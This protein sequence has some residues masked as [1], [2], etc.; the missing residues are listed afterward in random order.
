MNSNNILLANKKRFFLFFIVIFFGCNLYSQD[1]CIDPDFQDKSIELLREFIDD[2]TYLRCKAFNSSV[3]KEIEFYTIIKRN[4][5]YVFYIHQKNVDAENGM[6]IY[7]YDSHMNLVASSIDP[8]TKKNTSVIC[9]MP[10]EAGR[11]YLKTTYRTSEDKCCLISLG[12]VKK[13]GEKY[14]PKKGKRMLPVTIGETSN[15]K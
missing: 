8:K 15:K 4:I 12:I 11:Y 14:L 7:L 5:L 9:Y 6:V 10:A 3:A 1:E 13:S 2:Y